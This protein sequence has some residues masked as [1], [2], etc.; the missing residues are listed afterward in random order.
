MPTPQRGTLSRD[1]NAAAPA[2]KHQAPARQNDARDTDRDARK[3]GR[4]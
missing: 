1:G 2:V 3:N 4:H